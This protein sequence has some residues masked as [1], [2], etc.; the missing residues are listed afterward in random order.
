MYLT[1][2]ELGT[3]PQ[4]L[5]WVDTNHQSLQRL[6]PSFWAMMMVAMSNHQESEIVWG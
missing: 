1:N 2:R 5:H 4:E 3:G 6:I